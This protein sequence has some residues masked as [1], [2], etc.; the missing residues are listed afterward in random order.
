MFQE[1]GNVFSGPLL[2]VIRVNTDLQVIMPDIVSCNSPDRSDSESY[3]HSITA[4]K[5]K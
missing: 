4:N 3:S 1:D 2:L 5:L